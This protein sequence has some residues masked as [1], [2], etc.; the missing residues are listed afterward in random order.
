MEEMYNL[1]MIMME[2]DLFR[3]S[4]KLVMSLMQTAL[5]F[6]SQQ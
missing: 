4:L 3:V 2:N 6:D 5:L 1:Q